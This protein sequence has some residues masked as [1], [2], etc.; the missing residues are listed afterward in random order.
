MIFVSIYLSQS[1]NGLLSLM[2]GIVVFFAVRYKLKWMFPVGIA[3]ALLCFFVYHASDT[4]Q[5]GVARFIVRKEYATADEISIAKAGESRFMVWEPIMEDIKK[6]PWLGSGYGT[7]G[8]ELRRHYQGHNS[9]LQIV[10]ETG[11]IGLVII[12][13]VLLSLLYVLFKISVLHSPLPDRA[14]WSGIAATVAAGLANATFESWLLALG[15]L[16]TLP[17]WLCAFLLLSR[18]QKRKKRRGL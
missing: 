1:R 13:P 5:S 15:N 2:L 12:L 14:L 16:G 8:A 17:F 11:F 4:V 7:G 9:Y 3:V 18:I 6:R 10:Q